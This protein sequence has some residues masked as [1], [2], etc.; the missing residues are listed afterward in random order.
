MGNGAAVVSLAEDWIE[1]P[2]A[3]AKIAASKSGLVFMIDA[4]LR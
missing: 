1:A 3:L 2:I 4:F